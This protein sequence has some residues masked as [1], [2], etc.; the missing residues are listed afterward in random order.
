MRKELFEKLNQADRIE[1]R[2]CELQ[3]PYFENLK[4]HVLLLCFIASFILTTLESY[5]AAHNVM[6]IG[7]GTFLV[8]TIIDWVG[9]AFIYHKL[10]KKYIEKLNVVAKR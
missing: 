7:A 10:D 1:Y 9:T 6:M 5:Q 4:W 8:I 2:L 3:I